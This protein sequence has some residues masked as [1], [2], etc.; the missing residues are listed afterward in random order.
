M[1]VY[2]FCCRCSTRTLVRSNVSSSSPQGMNCTVLVRTPAAAAA[3]SS[4]IMKAFS[5]NLPCAFVVKTTYTA[6]PPVVV[7]VISTDSSLLANEATTAVTITTGRVRFFGGARRISL[8]ESTVVLSLFRIVRTSAC[9][10][11]WNHRAICQNGIDPENTSNC[12][13]L[14]NLRAGT[15]QLLAAF[16]LCQ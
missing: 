15:L 12:R 8:R 14:V 3:P 11:A 10:S 13:L 2:R 5:L 4:V 16:S 1:P 7:I 9:V 6:A